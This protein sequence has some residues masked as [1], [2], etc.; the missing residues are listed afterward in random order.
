[1]PLSVTERV[2]ALREEIAAIKE[3]N[4]TFKHHKN[5]VT[6]A[7]RERRRQRLEEI[8]AE[9]AGMTEWKKL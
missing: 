2:R 9:L 5:S 7:E 1:M 6:D 8:Q 4:E 3:M